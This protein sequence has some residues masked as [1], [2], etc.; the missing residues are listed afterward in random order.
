MR[1]NAPVVT[2]VHDQGHDTAVRRTGAKQRAAIGKLS[3]R[4][5]LVTGGGRGIGRSIALAFAAAG[6]DVAV[7]ARSGPQLAAVVKQIEGHGVKGLAVVADAM[8]Y[9]DTRDAVARVVAE[10]WDVLATAWG[11]DAAT[12]Q[13]RAAADALQNR[14]LEPDEL[15][16]MAVLLASDDGYGITGQVISVDGGFKV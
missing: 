2:A 4:V 16:P 12:A 6:C 7:T 11:V 14:V 3:N 15:G 1:D 13:A 8:S 10:L 9:T 5:A